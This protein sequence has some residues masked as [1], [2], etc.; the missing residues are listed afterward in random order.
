[1][2]VHFGEIGGEW[3][4]K[5]LDMSRLV[6][7]HNG[8]LL[9]VARYEE[10]EGLVVKHASGH[11]KP[12]GIMGSVF[13]NVRHPTHLW[14]GQITEDGHLKVN[15]M[16]GTISLPI[17]EFALWTSDNNPIIRNSPGP[18]KEVFDLLLD[19]AHPF[20]CARLVACLRITG[21]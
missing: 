1:M 21:K 9:L 14:L 20:S 13:W 19:M 2:I 3:E 18:N 7:G 5:L 10:S 11:A 6:D 15:V 17:A 16:D 4:K 8:E 12:K